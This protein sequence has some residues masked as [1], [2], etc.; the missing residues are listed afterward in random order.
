MF[1]SP[2]DSAEVWAGKV[3]TI[4][5][6]TL[7]V[8]RYKANTAISGEWM[9]VWESDT[10]ATKNTRTCPKQGQYRQHLVKIAPAAVLSTGELVQGSGARK[11]AS[12]KPY[13]S[14][15]DSL[16]KYAQSHGMGGTR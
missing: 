9:P 7:L 2:E 10:Q 11:K 12:Q 1:E 14:L 15:S 8:H 6:D 3:H 5:K 4:N 13:S 16:L